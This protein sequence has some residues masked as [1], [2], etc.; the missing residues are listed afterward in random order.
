MTHSCT[1][2]TVEIA[3]T[4]A[5]A[6]AEVYGIGEEIQV[7]EYREG[8][9]KTGHITK[10]TGLNKSTDVTLKRGVIAGDTA[11]WNWFKSVRDGNN[12]RRDVAI[13]LLD[14]QRQPVMRWLLHHAFP[15]KY[16]GPTFCALGNEVAIETLVLT[17]DG[18]DV[19]SA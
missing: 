1:R 17:H 15:V 14:E 6:F 13:I 3:G 16:E 5:A 19:V 4:T 7:V 11:L 18:L 12:D 8:S 10:V 2:F 9:D